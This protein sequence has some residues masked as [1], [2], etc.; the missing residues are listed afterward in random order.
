[1][2][3]TSF[4]HLVPALVGP[5]GELPDLHI[6]VISTDLGSGDFASPHTSCGADGDQA[7]LLSEPRLPA[8]EAIDGNYLLRVNAGGEILSNFEGGIEESF[9]CMAVLGS[10][11]CEYEQPLEAMRRALDGSVAENAGFLRADAVL[12]VVFLTDEDDC[13]A[14]VPA[15][16]DPD[17]PDL[18]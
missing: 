4:H 1:E 2:L 8:C 15:L 5:D 10:R 12:G 7:R 13:S 16:F 17:N 3:A 6:G 9:Q 18:P 11:G 14:R